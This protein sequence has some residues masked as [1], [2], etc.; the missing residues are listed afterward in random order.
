MH[1]WLLLLLFLAF[2]GLWIWGKAA[3]RDGLQPQPGNENSHNATTYRQGEKL[4]TY[5]DLKKKNRGTHLQG[6]SQGFILHTHAH[7]CHTLLL[8]WTLKSEILFPK[9]SGFPGELTQLLMINHVTKMS[10]VFWG[11]KCYLIWPNQIIVF[12]QPIYFSKIR[13]FPCLSYLF[14]AQVV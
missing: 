9:F 1:L 14:G 2:W 13:G 7:P 10:M 3:T 6:R 12:H 4:P 8:L 11:N 5:R